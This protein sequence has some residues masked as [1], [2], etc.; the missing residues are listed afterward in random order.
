MKVFKPIAI[1]VVV[2]IGG[3]LFSTIK[4]QQLINQ[5]SLIADEQCLKVNPIIIDRKNSYIKSMQAIKDNDAKTYEK[6]T[7]NYLLA[8]RKYV[9]QQTKWLDTQ[10]KYMDSWDFQH[11]VPQY[12]KSAAKAQYDSRKA[13]TESTNLLIDAFEV[14]Q[15]NKTLSEELGTKAVEQIKIRNA[16]DKKYDE[17]WNNP[18]KLDWRTRFIKVPTSKCPDGNFNIPDVQDFLNPKTA[19]EGYGAPIS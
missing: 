4:Y 6:E 17:I 3:A 14:A 15:L 11:F 13:D 2:I 7:D 18:G 12:V 10:K 8:S 19:P 1:V 5:G 16:A 9:T